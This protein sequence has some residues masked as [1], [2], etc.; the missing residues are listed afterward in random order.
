MIGKDFITA[1]DATFTI[2]EPDGTHHTYRCQHVEGQQEE[3]A[4]LSDPDYNR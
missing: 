3:A 1:G 4:F 2:Q